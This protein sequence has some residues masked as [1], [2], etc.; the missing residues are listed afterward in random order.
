M[1]TARYSCQILMKFYVSPQ[2]LKNK[3]NICLTV[4]H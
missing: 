2:M 4:H 3:F 1:G